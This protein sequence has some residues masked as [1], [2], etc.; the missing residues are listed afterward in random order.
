[1]DLYRAI[2]VM[3]LFI[4]AYLLWAIL[5]WAVLPHLKVF[6]YIPP[7]AFWVNLY[8][9]AA[10]AATAVF[11]WVLMGLFCIWV[12]W[13]IIKNFIPAWILFIPLRMILLAIP[14]FPQLEAAGIL[15]LIDKVFWLIVSTLPLKDR[16]VG[17][18]RAFQEYISTSMW[19]V[20]DGV[21]GFTT[22]PPPNRPPSERSPPPPSQEPD[23][24]FR[25]KETEEEYSACIEE[26]TQTIY[27]EMTGL[28]KAQ[29]MAKNSGVKATCSLKKLESMS[30][31]L[32]YRDLN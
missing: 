7:Q 3:V 27:P 18:G 8:S 11:H 26:N 30:R 13:F 6:P 5:R 9:A 17:A 2:D 29:A 23:H 4:A 24:E 31:M 16:L 12:V 32:Q 20:I 15:P 25:D 1:M 28:E 14:P 21:R 19:Y 22:G 10:G